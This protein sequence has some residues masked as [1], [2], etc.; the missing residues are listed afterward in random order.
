MHVYIFLLPKLNFMISEAT[1][2][3]ILEAIYH[4]TSRGTRVCQDT[5]TIQGHARIKQGL[6]QSV[7]HATLPHLYMNCIVNPAI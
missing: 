2:K 3:T 4:T 1:K 7:L 5:N 6:V